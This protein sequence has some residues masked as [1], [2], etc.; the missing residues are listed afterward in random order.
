[1]SDTK[2]KVIL[3]AAAFGCGA[4]FGAAAHSVFC[5]SKSSLSDKISGALEDAAEEAFS[6][7]VRVAEKAVEACQATQ[8]DDYFSNL[9]VHAF[10][11]AC[12]VIDGALPEESRQG[13]QETI[14]DCVR[15]LC[16]GCD[17]ENSYI[18]QGFMIISMHFKASQLGLND[19]YP[20]DIAGASLTASLS[21]LERQVDQSVYELWKPRAKEAVQ[22]FT[23][24]LREAK[25]KAG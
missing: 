6:S 3:A 16:E 8:T 2:D 10:Y 5:A 11:A 23:L 24:A 22:R 20:Q 19:K 18:L 13:W 14:K 1:M 17:A 21:R 9:D 12:E 25:L 15:F 4:V 7:V